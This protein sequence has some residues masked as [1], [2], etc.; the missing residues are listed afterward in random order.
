LPFAVL[1]ADDPTVL[2]SVIVTGT[3]QLGRSAPESL[4]PVDVVTDEV[5]RSSVSSEM[6]DV[7]MEAVPSFNVQRLTIGE[8]LAFVRPARLRRSVAGS[9]L[10]ARQR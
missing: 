8:G 9:N 3:R 5:I 10:G 4:A 6:T 1:A 2:Q 7:L